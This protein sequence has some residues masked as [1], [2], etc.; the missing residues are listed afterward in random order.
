MNLRDAFN[1]SKELINRNI[2]YIKELDKNKYEAYSQ[3]RRTHSN[4]TKYIFSFSTDNEPII[5]EE[6]EIS[7]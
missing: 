7:N 5:I 4:I 3:S 2:C 1:L 6:R